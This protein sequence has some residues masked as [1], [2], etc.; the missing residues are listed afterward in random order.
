M[1]LEDAYKIMAIGY[2]VAFDFK[3]ED[4][5]IPDS[6]PDVANGELYIPTKERAL[7]LAEMFY[8]TAGPNY[9]NIRVQD[10]DN[11]DVCFISI[12]RQY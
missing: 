3:G 11:K 9:K 2:I 6:F 1:K 12:Q 10:Q 5:I 4:H 7:Q 8:L